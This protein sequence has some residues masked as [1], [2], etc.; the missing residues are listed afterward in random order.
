MAWIKS[1]EELALHAKT[2]KAARMLAIGIPQLIGHLNL[3]WWWTMNNAPSGDLSFASPEDIADGAMWEGDAQVFVDALVG[4]S[5]TGGAGFLDQT[6]NGLFVHDWAQH[7]GTTIQ[8]QKANAQKQKRYREKQKNNDSVTVTLPL[9]N[10]EIT[11]R[12]GSQIEKEKEINTKEIKDTPQSCASGDAS[13]EVLDDLKVPDTPEATPEKM[14]TPHV[15]QPHD[16]ETPE[17]IAAMSVGY[18]PEFEAFWAQYPRKVAK[19]ASFIAWRNE[20]RTK[21]DKA[22]LIPATR[23]F[24]VQ[25]QAEQRPQDKIMHPETFLRKDRWREYVG[26]ALASEAIGDLTQGE[27]LALRAKYTDEEGICDAKAMHREYRT[28]QRERGLG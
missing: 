24:S 21:A 14:A 1:H 5:V 16:G 8:T 2:K 4:C 18:P 3:L 22:D 10:E 11:S 19:K 17:K 26:G 12:Y 20:A 25:M 7:G 23:N 28:L 13:G 15:G 27:K 6:D 9:H